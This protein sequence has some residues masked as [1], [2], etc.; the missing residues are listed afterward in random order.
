MDAIIDRKAPSI[1]I[2]D[3]SLDLVSTLKQTERLLR[4]YL[5]PSR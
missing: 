3:P 1:N 5:G 2:A 4:G